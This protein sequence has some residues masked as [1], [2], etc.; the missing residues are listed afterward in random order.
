MSDV[1][2]EI[3]GLNDILK[4]IW[5]QDPWLNAQIP[6]TDDYA[7]NR[8]YEDGLGYVERPEDLPPT[9]ASVNDEG[10]V[11][12]TKASGRIIVYAASYTLRIGTPSK[13]LTRKLASVFNGHIERMLRGQICNL[14]SVNAHLLDSIKLVTAE[15]GLRLWSGQLTATIQGRLPWQQPL[16]ARAL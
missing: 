1:D 6:A 16:P 7:T 5:Q 2:L 4:A 13:A 10:A 15:S 8:F 14:G 11:K 9:F 12:S 3:V